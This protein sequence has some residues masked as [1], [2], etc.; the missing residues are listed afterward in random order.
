[1][2]CLHR[3]EQHPGN[4]EE[5]AAN[6]QRCAGHAQGEA[7]DCANAGAS[8]DGD[9]EALKVGVDL[10]FRLEDDK[11]ERQPDQFY[12]AQCEQQRGGRDVVPVA[13]QQA[14]TG[15]YCQRRG[16]MQLSTEQLLLHE[17]RPVRVVGRV[18]ERRVALEDEREGKAD[19]GDDSDESDNRS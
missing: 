3:C 2:P 1:M 6:S 8:D 17:G 12:C 7:G 16:D 5:N 15:T 10:F 4:Q 19:T 14:G 18:V 13:L 11:H 9:R